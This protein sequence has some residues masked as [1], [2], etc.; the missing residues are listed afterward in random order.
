[1]K[2]KT[3][4]TLSEDVIKTIDKLSGQSKNRSKFIEKAV[5]AYVAQMIRRE[6]N[7]RDLEILNQRA[8]QLNEEARDVL[9]YQGDW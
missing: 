8:D 6:L 5:R 1:M 9:A 3:S 4:V 7:A 2:T